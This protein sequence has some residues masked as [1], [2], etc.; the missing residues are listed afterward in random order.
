MIRQWHI[1]I[2]GFRENLYHRSGTEQLFASLR[3]LAGPEVS[4]QLRLWDEDWDAYAAYLWRNSEPDARLIVF[5][6]SWGAAGA[7]SSSA[8]PWPNSRPKTPG[9]PPPASPA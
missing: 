1:C 9:P 7:P 5:G 8:A 6:Y 4:A 2:S 3:I